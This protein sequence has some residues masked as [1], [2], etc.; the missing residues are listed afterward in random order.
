MLIALYTIFVLGGGGTFGPMDFIN[1]ALDNTD[2]AIV[3]DDRRKEAIATLKT[4]KAR[5]KQHTKAMKGLSKEMD[6]S[7]SEHEFADEETEVTWDHFF[8]LNTEYSKDIVEIRF[9]L[10]DQVTRE[11]WELMFPASASS[12]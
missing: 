5:T 1:E 6:S 7:M 2:S 9:Q 11:E 10:R 4:M 8:E 3:D 12:N